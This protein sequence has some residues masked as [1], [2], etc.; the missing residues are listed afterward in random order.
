MRI[1]Q[2]QS[3]FGFVCVLNQSVF[4]NSLTGVCKLEHPVWGNAQSCLCQDPSGDRECSPWLVSG[5]PAHIWANQKCH[6]LRRVT[7]QQNTS[8]GRGDIPL[9]CPSPREGHSEGM[10]WAWLAAPSLWDGGSMPL[11]PG[12][13]PGCC[14]AQPSVSSCHRS[15]TWG[16]SNCLIARPR[17]KLSLR[18][19]APVQPVVCVAVPV[20]PEPSQCV[21]AQHIPPLRHWRLEHISVILNE[22]LF[23][24]EA[25][26]A[27][28]AGGSQV[29]WG[30]CGT[31]RS[32]AASSA[33]LGHLSAGFLCS[34]RGG[35]SLVASETFV[36]LSW[37][38][39]RSSEQGWPHSAAPALGSYGVPWGA[40]GFCVLALPRHSP[41]SGAHRG[42]QSCPCPLCLPTC[43]PGGCSFPVFSL[44][45][46]RLTALMV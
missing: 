10:P 32:W 41:R 16:L 39:A 2:L 34:A 19:G 42:I 40:I 31:V 21:R 22:E 23:N 44:P 35:A 3:L 6:W 5:S 14:P 1:S 30:S 28:G 20:C 11:A 13:S 33:A 27:S 18:A 38:W 46:P 24:G 26:V 4:V 17:E 36:L 43:A 37:S 8:A 45:R 15:C 25:A 29:V 12:G 9:C 7:L